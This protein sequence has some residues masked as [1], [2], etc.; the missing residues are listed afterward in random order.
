MSPGMH[1][2]IPP[3]MAPP[4]CVDPQD[5]EALRQW[6]LAMMSENYH[7]GNEAGGQEGSGGGPHPGPPPGFPPNPFFPPAMWPGQPFAP[8]GMPSGMPPGCFPPF[9]PTYGQPPPGFPGDDYFPAMARSPPQPSPSL[10]AK[11]RFRNRDRGGDPRHMDMP[12]GRGSQSSPR[13]LHQLESSSPGH[14]AG[15]NHSGMYDGQ[16]GWHTAN[17][18][19]PPGHSRHWQHHGDEPQQADFLS[20]PNARRLPPLITSRPMD[21]GSTG[22]PSSGS[23]SQITPSKR[24]ARDLDNGELSDEDEQEA[25]RERRKQ[26]NRESARR[27]RMRKQAESE[28]LANRILVLNQLNSSLKEELHEICQSRDD[29]RKQQN[30]LQNKVDAVAREGVVTGSMRK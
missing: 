15:R 27:S 1:L 4:P 13:H 17:D 26:S 8:P 3:G 10:Q 5:R 28:V 9:P 20:D 11:N 18:L 24:T 2:P 14:M 29:L 16:F 23:P 30:I 7:Y 22:P 19:E 21:G 12:A 6:H 25:K